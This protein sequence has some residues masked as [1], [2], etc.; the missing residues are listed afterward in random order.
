MNLIVDAF[1]GDEGTILLF[2]GHD[3]TTDK[4]YT[5]AVDHRIGWE[6]AHTLT[7]SEEEILVGVEGWQ[8]IG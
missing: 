1:V 4:S 2:E 8:I 6:L 5:F 3:E 7:E